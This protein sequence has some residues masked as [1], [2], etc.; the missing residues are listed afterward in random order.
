MN[1]AVDHLSFEELRTMRIEINKRLTDWGALLPILRK[2]ENKD[3]KQYLN[4]FEYYRDLYGMGEI[5]N[6]PRRVKS[7]IY[8][9]LIEY[10]HT[11]KVECMKIL[12]AAFG[13]GD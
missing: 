6:F 4:A 11:V 12:I 3:F 9:H 2:I 10:E 13:L 1:T 8:H 7:D 5:D